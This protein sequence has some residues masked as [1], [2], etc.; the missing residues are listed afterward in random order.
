M[1]D[2]YEYFDYP[3]DYAICW[4]KMAV[5]SIFAKEKNI[6]MVKEDEEEE[7]EK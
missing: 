2:L 1:I 5:L 4:K 7:E 6:V 3:E